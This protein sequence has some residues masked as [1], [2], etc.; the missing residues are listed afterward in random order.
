MREVS[1]LI[2]CDTG[3]FSSAN[4]APALAIL[5]D[6]W[7]APSMPLQWPSSDSATFPAGEMRD[8]QAR[9]PYQMCIRDQLN[10]N[11]KEYICQAVKGKD[12][13]EA[14][15]YAKDKTI[16]WVLKPHC[17]AG[18][19]AVRENE[20][21]FKEED[22]CQ[23]YIRMNQPETAPPARR[24][25]QSDTLKAGATTY[26]IPGPPVDNATRATSGQC[27]QWNKVQDSKDLINPQTTG[28]CEDTEDKDQQHNYEPENTML[29]VNRLFLRREHS[30]PN[31]IK[32]V[33]GYYISTFKLGR[34]GVYTA[35]PPNLP[36]KLKETGA[37]E[38]AEKEAF[39]KIL[40]ALIPNARGIAERLRDP[41]NRTE[42]ARNVPVEVINSLLWWFEMSAADIPHHT[43]RSVEER[44]DQ[45]RMTTLH[46]K[47]ILQSGTYERTGVT[48]PPQRRGGKDTRQVGPKQLG[49][50]VGD[51]THLK[52]NNKNQHMVHDKHTLLYDTNTN[53][54]RTE[55]NKE[56]APASLANMHRTPVTT[57]VIQDMD[58]AQ[59][60]NRDKAVETVQEAFKALA[61]W[62][63]NGLP[64]AMKL[65]L[66]DLIHPIQKTGVNNHKTP[67]GGYTVS[68]TG[69]V[70]EPMLEEDEVKAKCN[71]HNDKTHPTTQHT[72]SQIT[73][74]HIT[75]DRNDSTKEFP[76]NLTLAPC[77]NQSP[78]PTC[79][80]G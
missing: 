10:S 37:E 23:Q 76:T 69:W 18:Y 27:Y 49:R 44:N 7:K 9:N 29:T 4:T 77:P 78:P 67:L 53:S 59:T 11:G 15:V 8:H 14:P 45:H 40:I 3:K 41:A 66:V 71:P 30:T 38:L 33:K 60:V 13:L 35:K 22:T 16:K 48:P 58:T 21:H 12:R 39:L 20:T 19:E 68:T 64:P 47:G 31:Q 80:A 72:V 51:H 50:G 26:Q 54:T 52:K 6:P 42:A 57:L 56:T 36:K 43:V 17:R 65:T 70:N 61:S 5:D 28:T 46:V 62:L 79:N 75:R 32:D 55:T 2:A 34:P 1:P 25:S 74:C 73:P 63:S 24:N